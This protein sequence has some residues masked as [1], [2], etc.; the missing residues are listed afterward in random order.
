[1]ANA[2]A[3]IA[4][5]KSLLHEIGLPLPFAPLLLCDNVS[6]MYLATNPILH[7]RTKHMQ[8]DYHF[9][10][11]RVM[12]SSLLLRFTPSEDQLADAFTKPLPTQ[13]FLN[14]RTKLTVLPRPVHLRGMLRLLPD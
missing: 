7:A 13:R 8:I 12:A 10:R 2:A 9:I 14:L 5:L 1:M 3:E 11:E 4:W 6:A